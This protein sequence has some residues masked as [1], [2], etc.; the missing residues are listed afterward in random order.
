M[1]PV[2]TR[3]EM[4]AADAAALTRV[5]HET[6]VG[7]AGTAV[8]HAALRMMGGAYGKQVVVIA[9]KGSNGAD[10]LVAAAYLESRGAR[11]TV[12][13][14]TEA[15]AALPS[16]DLVIDGAYGTGFHGAYDAPQAPPGTPVLAI[17]VPSGLDADT[18][19]AS[20]AATRAT[21]TVTFAALKPGLLQGDGPV[22]CGAV[23][24]ADIGIDA[25]ASRA[26]VMEDADVAA[27]VPARARGSNKWTTALGIAAGSVGMEGSAILCTRGALATGAG[28][29]RLGSP[30]DPSGGWPVEAV[31][32]SLPSTGWATSFTAATEKCQ[33]LVIGPGLGTGDG[34]KQEIR[35][36][37]AAATVPL[38]LDADGL[39]ALGHVTSARDLLGTPHR[40][41]R[42]HPPRRRVRPPGRRAT[43]G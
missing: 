36:V 9:G 33:A 16:C 39:T 28:M 1:Q 22:H 3:D 40:P 29:I 43:R 32:M 21:R 26:A 38:V 12:I 4:R 13:G 30:G 7:R 2:L 19:A 27:L 24:V 10:G 18:G 23:E 37:I 20:G 35:A 17:D 14:A 42:A 8:A 34:T 11:V 15:P 5:S 31:R 6:L 25:G 41:D